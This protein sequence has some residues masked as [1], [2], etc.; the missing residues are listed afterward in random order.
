MVFV[1]DGLYIP[2]GFSEF[3]DSS[4]ISA[5]VEQEPPK[6]FGNGLPGEEMR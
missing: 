1:K 4:G 5:H 3:A 2:T 6:V